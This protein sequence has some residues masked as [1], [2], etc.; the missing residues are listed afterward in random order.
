MS[1]PVIGV[2]AVTSVG[3]T[4]EET[5]ESLCAGRSGL[6]PMRGFAPEWYHAGHLYELDNRPDPGQDVTGRATALLLDAVGQ[7][8]DAAGLD[9]DLGDIPVLVGTGLRELRSVELWWRDGAPLEAADL[10]FGTALRRTFQAH[11]TLTVSN[12]CSA[13][14]HTLALGIDL[15]RSGEAE[16][17][18]VAGVDVITESMFGLAD[19]V[20]PEPPGQVRPFDVSRKGTVLGEGASAVV[21]T[22]PERGRGRPIAGRVREVGINCDAYHV[23]APDTEW[24]AEAVRSAHRR[25]GVKPDDIDLVM[26]HGTGTPLNDEAEATA[27][28]EVFGDTQPWMTGLKGATGHTSGA[29]GLLSVI[30]GMLAMASGRIPPIVGLDEPIESISPFRLVRT[31]AVRT[32]SALCQVDAFGFG[33][34]NSVAIVEAA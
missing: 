18:V 20:Q 8:V 2:G 21:L 32:E 1:W 30:V 6:A 33:G 10:H 26:L 13:S 14:L 5:F 16:T 11:D 4:A 22:T 24:I 31:D 19:R 7:A 27:L 25:A 23:T 34:L 28:R 17:V 29:S 9:R 12:A 15:L 3:R